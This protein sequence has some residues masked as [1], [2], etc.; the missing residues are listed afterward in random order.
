MA[1]LDRLVVLW[2]RV[3]LVLAVMTAHPSA[4][5]PQEAVRSLRDGDCGQKE[6]V[7]GRFGTLDIVATCRTQGPNRVMHIT[8]KNQS[9]DVGIVTSFSVG[10]CR[11]PV[12]EIISPPGWRSEQS[13]GE[14]KWLL[15]SPVNPLE[16]GVGADAQ[17]SGFSIVLRPGWTQSRSLSY[18]AI[19]SN[20]GSGAVTAVTHDCPGP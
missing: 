10:F 17:Q 9:V 3:A 5:A 14:V 7:I 8:L 4:S 20:G 18:G 11:N 6:Q 15:P 16:H 2:R 13:G 12:V 19:A 1:Q